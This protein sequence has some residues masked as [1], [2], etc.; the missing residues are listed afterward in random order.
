MRIQ[1][2]PF[3]DH[4]FKHLDVALQGQGITDGKGLVCTIVVF[5]N[6]LGTLR[7]RK[8]F[9]VPVKQGVFLRQAGEPGIRSRCSA[10][11]HAVPANFLDRV[12]ADGSAQCL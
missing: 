7:Q 8:G 5:E 9:A 11:A 6:Q 1:G 4:G 2:G 3:A 12:G 10:T